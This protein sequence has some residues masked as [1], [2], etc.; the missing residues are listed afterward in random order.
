MFESFHKNKFSV[1]ATDTQASSKK[2]AIK[3][4]NYNDDNKIFIDEEYEILKE[5]GS[6]I[7]MVSF[8]GIF[9]RDRHI[10]FVL[11]VQL[12]YTQFFLLTSLK[13]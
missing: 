8:Y 13:F 10:W 11:E 6:C 12:H 5:L 9:Q 1:E 2:V 4:Q 3:V 7:Y